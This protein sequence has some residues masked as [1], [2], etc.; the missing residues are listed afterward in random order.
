MKAKI[1]RTIFIVLG[2][3]A[4]LLGVVGIFLPLLPTTPFLLLAAMCFNRG[5]EK[6]HAWLLN[7]KVLGAPILDWQNRRVIKTKFK[8]LATL[9]LV[10]SGIMLVLRES[11]SVWLKVGFFC[12][13]AGT[14]T[15]IWLQKGK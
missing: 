3:L 5:S 13:A 10:A 7:H 2:S 9:M 14:L 4:L 15:F 6:F 11:V 12:F 8:V 1:K